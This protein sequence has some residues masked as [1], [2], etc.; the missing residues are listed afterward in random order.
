MFKKVPAEQPGKSSDGL[1]VCCTSWSDYRSRDMADPDSLLND[2]EQNNGVYS[3]AGRPDMSKLQE[4][5][6]PCVGAES[7]VLP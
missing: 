3:K 4:K 2:R 7:S 5:T 6:C 1:N